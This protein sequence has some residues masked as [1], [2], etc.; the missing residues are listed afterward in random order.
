MKPNKAAKKGSIGFLALLLLVSGHAFGFPQGTPAN[1]L[2]RLGP[3]R[4]V[5]LQ[6]ERTHIATLTAI[7]QE[8][9]LP[10]RFLME[11]TLFSLAQL[12]ATEALPAIDALIQQDQGKDQN[13]GKTDPNIVHAAAFGALF[14]ILSRLGGP[15]QAILKHF[16][17]DPDPG[18][19]EEARRSAAG[20]SV[21][22][23]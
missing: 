17:R 16:E 8:Q 10:S 6:N 18:I 20:Q 1:D 3:A 5:G 2:E 19:A 9:P 21:P 14:A 11:A 4:Q 23:Y 7:V 13:K 15:S 12:G 22:G